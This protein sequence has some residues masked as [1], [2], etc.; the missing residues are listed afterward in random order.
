MDDWYRTGDLGYR[1]GEGYYVAGRLKDVLIVGG[2]NVFP[3]DIE[4]LVSQIDGVHPGRVSA[5]STFDDRLQTEHIVIV[6]ESDHHDTVDARQVTLEIRQ[7]TLAAFQ[8]AN[9]E[10]RLVEPGWL[11]K[12]TAGK[13][14]RSANRRKWS[15]TV[16]SS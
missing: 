13:M 7:R 3:Q 1:V 8:I 10:V 11:V 6:A 16:G 2:V 14:A 15:D 9:F 12:S 4:D 5:F